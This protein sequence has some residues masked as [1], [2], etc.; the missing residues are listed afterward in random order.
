MEK[1]FQLRQLVESEQFMDHQDVLSVVLD[2]KRL[3]T[4]AEAQ[5]ILNRIL[6]KEVD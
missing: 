6:T 5:Q 1:K 2:P 4:K 3:Y